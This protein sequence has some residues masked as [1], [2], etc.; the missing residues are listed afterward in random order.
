M[1]G[2][3]VVTYCEKTKLSRLKMLNW[4]GVY[5]KRSEGYIFI[6]WISCAFLYC[7]ESIGDT[8]N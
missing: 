6:L 5:T 7:K 2:F 4:N 3:H 8:T 1:H